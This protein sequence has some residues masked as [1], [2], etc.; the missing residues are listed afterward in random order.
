LSNTKTLNVSV[1]KLK[2]KPEALVNSLHRFINKIIIIFILMFYGRNDLLFYSHFFINN[3][4][5]SN[6]LLFTFINYFVYFVISF[7]KKS[8]LTKSIDYFFSLNNLL[9]LLPLIFFLNSILI[10][11]FFIE[12]LSALIFFKLISSQIWFK[13]KKNKIENKIPQKYIN[14]VFF[15]FWVTFFSTIFIIFFYINIFYIYGSTEWFLTQ[16]VN[17]IGLVEYYKSSSNNIKTLVLIFTTSIIFKL[18]ITPLHLFKLE[19]Y[20]GIPLISILFYTIYFL[21][22]FLFFFL[23]FFSELVTNFN[24][25]YYVLFVSCII[26]GCTYIMFLIF[27]INSIKIFLTYSTIINIMGV[28]MVIVTSF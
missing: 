6:F 11:L 20:K 24:H 10:F 2:L 19:V 23:F 9:L 21:L 22:I 1:K 15:Q 28:L 13:K 16:F 8:N 25:F 7:F 18:G 17:G 3:F 5:L 27:D 12:M 26:I 14:M 4:N